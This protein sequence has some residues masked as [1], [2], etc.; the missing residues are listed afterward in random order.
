M[1]VPLSGALIC[2]A[3]SPVNTPPVWKVRMVNWVPGSPM[4]WAAI[5]PTASPRSTARPVAKL[6]P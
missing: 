2:S 4:D 5:I 3:T 1:T 6:Q